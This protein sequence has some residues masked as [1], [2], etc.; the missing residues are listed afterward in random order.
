MFL[1]ASSSEQ[2]GNPNTNDVSAADFTAL[3]DSPIVLH[4]ADLELVSCVIRREAKIIVIAGQNQLVVRI[5]DDITSDQWAATIPP[6]SY[7]PAEL[8]VQVAASL[9]EFPIPALRTWT[10]TIN[11]SNQL[12]ITHV[13][14][15]PR[16]D[17]NAQILA[18]LP[19]VPANQFTS[20][21]GPQWTPFTCAASGASS[22]E[23]SGPQP[24]SSTSA[25]VADEPKLVVGSL[26]TGLPGAPGRAIDVASR[27]ANFFTFDNCVLH[28]HDGDVGL[29]VKHSGG[30]N[31]STIDGLHGTDEDE[32]VFKYVASSNLDPLIQTLNLGALVTGEFVCCFKIR[33]HSRVASDVPGK[34]STRYSMES[35]LTDGRIVSGSFVPQQN[36][37][38]MRVNLTG[39]MEID[40][41]I[42]DS[43][44]VPTG[45]NA[46]ETVYLQSN[47]LYTSAEFTKGDAG[48]TGAAATDPL[49]VGRFDSIE[50]FSGTRSYLYTSQESLLVGFSAAAAPTTAGGGVTTNICYKPGSIGR[51]NI[52]FTTAPQQPDKTSSFRFRAARY[53]ILSVNATG[54]ITQFCVLDPGEG[55]SDSATAGV[56]YF[57]DPATMVNRRPTLNRILNNGGATLSLA[58]SD[59]S[60][61]FFRLNN[62]PFLNGFAMQ[63]AKCYPYAGVG[64]V[65]RERL[66]SPISTTGI[67]GSIDCDV[68][69]EIT[70]KVTSTGSPFAVSVYQSLPQSSAYNDRVT[71]VLINEA[72]P[73]SWNTSLT[74][75]SGTAPANWATFI[76]GES[77]RVLI[78]QFQMYNIKVHIEHARRCCCVR[79]AT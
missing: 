72:Q 1:A 11:A 24:F 51:F 2:A 23:I 22:V 5:G 61:D 59:V 65:P 25:G 41:T 37:Y 31:A 20:T 4:K 35:Q 18:T 34:G 42:R 44:L 73:H 53:K 77:V 46:G 79:R 48:V 58:A 64:I 69:V 21:A 62:N 26:E 9:N 7:T 28:P 36:Y 74:Y 40:T 3:F 19:E 78:T 13:G 12:V 70:P 71:N 33:T 55:Y 56:L 16:L 17:E 39:V 76:N 66:D 49:Q 75:T 6:G 38:L 54:G 43:S 68:W 63:Q 47:A 27:P 32:N 57:D 50:S 30:Y 67:S 10:C 60:T 14:I 52:A 8:A 15:K 29:D 45:V